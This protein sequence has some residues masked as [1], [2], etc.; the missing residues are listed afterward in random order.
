MARYLLSNLKSIN[1]EYDPKLHGE[2]LTHDQLKELKEANFLYLYKWEKS[3][4]MICFCVAKYYSLAELNTYQENDF[5]PYSN[6]IIEVLMSGEFHDHSLEYLL[7]FLENPNT[8]KYSNGYFHYAAKHGN[9]S[10]K[11]WLINNRKEDLKVENYS[12]PFGV[13]NLTS[14][15]NSLQFLHL[16]KI[17]IDY[18]RIISDARLSF[19]KSRVLLYTISVENI[20]MINT[21]LNMGFKCD[22]QDV[23]RFYETLK[24]NRPNVLRILIEKDSLPP[25]SDVQLKDILEECFCEE[26]IEILELMWKHQIPF[27][28]DQETFQYCSIQILRWWNNHSDRV[29]IEEKII[30]KVVP[31]NKLSFCHCESFIYDAI[32]DGEFEAA[33]FWIQLK[34]PK[35]PIQI[36]K[37]WLLDEEKFNFLEKIPIGI[38]Y[39]FYWPLVKDLVREC[40]REN[41]TIRDYLQKSDNIVQ[42]R[43]LWCLENESQ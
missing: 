39:I 42:R 18:P 19:N 26:S 38:D 12:F 10:V 43:L 20:E 8:K 31:P 23:N 33:E 29:I 4:A 36:R 3:S 28:Y 34:E 1:C 9:R 41:I 35:E 22:P 37:D 15:M 24:C 14:L 21:Y 25:F 17:P 6:S 40:F 16:H 27:V 7:P 13:T 2:Y 30:Q 11:E 32:S 5:Y